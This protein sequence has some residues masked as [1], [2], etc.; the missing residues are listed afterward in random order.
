VKEAL[1]NGRWNLWLPDNIADWD[2]ITGDYVARHGWEFVRFESM[3]KHLHYGD[4]LYDIGAEHGWISAVLGREF[5][6]PEN[7]VLIEPSYEFWVNIRRTWKWNN[8]EDPAACWYGFMSDEGSSPDWFGWPSHADVTKPEVPGM[9]YGSL[10]RNSN[11]PVTTV[12]IFSEASGVIP[13]ALNIDVEGAEGRVL[14][15]A[16]KTLRFERRLRNVWVSIH[17]DLMERDFGEQKDDLI[18]W[19]AGLG[20]DGVHLGTDHE[21]HWHFRKVR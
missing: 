7:M 15:G 4:I 9:P 20:W 8:L 18:A 5:V 17:P 14:R 12:D 1:V 10:T 13:A 21:E 11:V 16:E 19:M 2:A 6:G 3:Q